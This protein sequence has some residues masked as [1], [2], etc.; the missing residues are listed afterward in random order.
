MIVRLKRDW[1]APN[2]HYYQSGLQDIPDSLKDSLP[3]GAEEVTDKRE[4]EAT[5]QNLEPHP[6]SQGDQ[7]RIGVNLAAETIH[8]AQ[9]GV[10][11]TSVGG[12]TATDKTTPTDS[13][14]KTL[15]LDKKK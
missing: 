10:Q 5:P 4:L 9:K 1:F 15:S 8:E 2:G 6:L 13:A 11:P 3:V 7:D 14:K 12:T